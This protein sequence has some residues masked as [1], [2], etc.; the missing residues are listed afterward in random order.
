MNPDHNEHYAEVEVPEM[1]LPGHRPL[2]L[3]LDPNC[4]P[5]SSIDLHLEHPSH[6]N[7]FW[8]SQ[9]A[10]STLVAGAS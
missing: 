5:Y 8:P 2:T 3:A 1:K 6:A 9:G 4:S 7:G 10:R